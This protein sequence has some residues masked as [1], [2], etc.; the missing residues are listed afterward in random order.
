MFR[1]KVKKSREEMQRECEQKT[2]EAI[3]RCQK[4]L[5][6]LQYTINKMVQGIADAKE[7]GCT[8]DER[9]FRIGLKQMLAMKRQIESQILRIKLNMHLSDL[10]KI[11][12]DFMESMKGISSLIQ[13]NVSKVDAKATKKQYMKTM[14]LLSKKNADM[15][16]AIMQMDESRQYALDIIDNSEDLAQYDSE[17]EI[18][19]ANHE[20]A[21][22]EDKKTVVN[23]NKGTL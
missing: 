21:K 16:D 18:L 4:N 6:D 8:T 9:D 19:L 13:Y 12:A 22:Q 14:Y 10:T 23:S 20:K 11:N 3:G 7:S 17:V 5:S 2:N 15:H 1:K